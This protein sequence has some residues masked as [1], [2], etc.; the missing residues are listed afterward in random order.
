ML[1]SGAPGGTGWLVTPLLPT[2]RPWA[3]PVPIPDMALSNA[4]GLWARGGSMELP[5]IEG[6][7]LV[8][9]WNCLQHLG[10]RPGATRPTEALAPPTASRL[11]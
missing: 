10:T 7:A 6:W 4:L 8:L 9:Y 11:K 1:G 5:Q 3:D 2:V